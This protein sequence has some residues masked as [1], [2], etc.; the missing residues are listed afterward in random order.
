LRIIGLV[1]LPG[2]G[3]S[4]AAQVAREMGL[5][6]VVMGDVI[7]QEAAA[8]G[9]PPTDEN[10][11]RLGSMLRVREGAAAVARRS[12][13]LARESGKDVA[14]IDGL[15]SKEEADY[16]RANAQEFHLLE[17]WARPEVRLKRLAF[18]GRSDDP[19]SGNACTDDR[20]AGVACD[21]KIIS[22]CRNGAKSMEEALEI[23]ECREL[24]WG[25]GQAFSE[26]EARLEND[27]DLEE[28][29]RAVRRLLSAWMGA[30]PGEE[31]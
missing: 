27:G 25:M 31:K 22:S 29:R 21:I 3:K 11:G 14:A 16:F 13:Q 26:A 5:G 30:V 19:G 24:G 28:F 17:I 18:R 20:N 12:L 2:S 10:L 1:G 8:R 15:R 6:V 4:E 7:R 9:L 23:R